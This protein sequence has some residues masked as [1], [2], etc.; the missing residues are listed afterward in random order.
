MSYIFTILFLLL[1]CVSYSQDTP[2]SLPPNP[3]DSTTLA[4]NDSIA[5]DVDTFSY[6]LD[7][8]NYI[9]DSTGQKIFGQIKNSTRIAAARHIYFKND[10]LEE[11]LYTP[12]EVIEWR[13]DGKVNRAKPYEINKQK[14]IQVFM[15]L[16]SPDTGMIQVY[17]FHNNFIGAFPITQTLLDKNGVLTEVKKGKFRKQMQAY[18]ADQSSIAQVFEDKKTKIKDLVTIVSQYNILV[19]KDPIQ[20]SPSNNANAAAPLYSTKKIDW[21]LD[22]LL[23]SPAEILAK[24]LALLEEETKNISNLD[25]KNLIVNYKLGIVFFDQTQYAIALP[26]LKRADVAIQQYI[27]ESN[28]KNEAISPEYLEE[29]RQYI[30]DNDAQLRIGYM[31]GQIYINKRKYTWAI[32]QNTRA[33]KAAHQSISNNKNQE[34]LYHAYLAQGQLFQQL[35]PSKKNV[36]W[37]KSSLTNSE[38][39]WEKALS[40]RRLKRIDNPL[41][42]NKNT[43]FNL[44]L[45]QYDNARQLIAQLEK[46]PEKTIE[47]KLELGALY[48]A[49]GDYSEARG[50]YEKVLSTIDRDY[51]GKH[52]QAANIRR[53]L[54]EICLAERLYKQ[55]LSY[56]EQ[57]QNIHIGAAPLDAK[58]L[59][60]IGKIPFPF[61]LLNTILTKGS[62]YYQQQKNKPSEESLQKVL[63][64]YVIA[65]KLLHKIRNTHRNEGYNYR[66]SNITHEFSQHAVL[67]CHQLYTLTNKRTYLE[68]AFHYAELSKSAVLYETVHGLKYKKIAGIPQTDIVQEN[69]LKIQISYLKSEIF[70]ELQKGRSRN[71]EKIEQ[72]ELLL[73]EAN[74][75]HQALLEQLE[76]QYPKYHALKYNYKVTSLKELQ[77]TLAPNEAFLQY[78]LSDSFVYVLAIC[79]DSIQSQLIATESSIAY[80]IKQ[81]H[82]ALKNNHP[83]LYQDQV[84]NLHPYIIGDLLPFLAGKKL[85]ISPDAELHYIPFGTLPVQIPESQASKG[86][87]YKNMEYIIE[88]HPICYNYSATLYLLNKNKP[89][90]ATSQ[91][92]GTWA[93][94]FKGM[95]SILKEKGI[96]SSLGDLPGAQKEVNNI[97]LLFETTP[98]L[99]TEA[100]EHHFKNVADQYAVLH[101]ATH[102]LLNDEAPLYSS[103]ILNNE[104]EEDGILHTFELYNMNLNADLAVLSAC[105]SGMGKL[106]KG[107]GV[108]SI[109]RGFAYAGVP[110]IVMSNWPVSDL[111]TLELMKAFYRY[112]KQGL[113]KDE[114]LQKAKIEYLKASKGSSVEAPFYWGGFV[115][116]GDNAP[117]EA[118]ISP[119]S[120]FNA[121]YIG[122]LV[123]IIMGIAGWW[124]RRQRP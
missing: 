14:T 54:G 10:D 117:V 61:E 96:F 86:E 63:A 30:K 79:H 65:T 1:C 107:A 40:K 68:Q 15:E 110:N 60:D 55:A 109:A 72:L 43:D 80:D 33:L 81:L 74:Q 8:T 85:I 39:S 31:L 4:A 104:G 34:Y 87:V 70:Y 56:I 82:K 35:Y 2:D 105:N 37:Y 108:L 21:N 47:T 112:L 17:E 114:A 6:S 73:A 3:I 92:I 42:I 58:L 118:L 88:R 71:K 64:H 94:D 69:G 101:I 67:V 97:S 75:K 20:A 27:D 50:Y 48:F 9:I 41:K 113:P 89:H 46:S 57:A 5:V 91:K 51:K 66:L 45:I 13:K 59:D 32:K 16:L 98:F 22:D 18:F 124:Y 106:T 23:L 76:Q 83:N 121:W 116:L 62:I 25:L 28:V 44:A 38:E 36:K 77:Q 26:Y 78:V 53:F 29:L 103:L 52:P 119:P 95:D 99:M 24:Y 111:S 49:A 11:K 120:S 84:R 122:L 115:L 123:L 19:K 12:Q 102:G 100:T 90:N 7:T 93:P